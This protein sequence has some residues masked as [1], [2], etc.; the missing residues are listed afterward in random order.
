MD[1]AIDGLTAINSWSGD[2]NTTSFEAAGYIAAAMLAVSLIFVVWALATKKE[3]AKA[4][5]IA[6]LV[7]LI[8]TIIFILK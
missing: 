5:L 6:W 2:F 3:S 8:F 7:A 1:D 4:Y